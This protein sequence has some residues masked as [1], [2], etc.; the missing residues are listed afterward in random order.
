MGHVISQ[1]VVMYRLLYLF[2][3]FSLWPCNK[4]I[5]DNVQVIIF[6]LFILIMGYV[7]SQ[8]MVMYHLFMEKP[9]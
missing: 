7:I 8:L 2:S 6:I 5:I 1:L 9:Y 4:S 3:S